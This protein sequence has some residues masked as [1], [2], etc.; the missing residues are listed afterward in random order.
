MNQTTRSSLPGRA[1]ALLSLAGLLLLPPAALPDSSEGGPPEQSG[2]G[3]M[4]LQKLL[5]DDTIAGWRQAGGDSTYDEVTIFRY[6]DGAGEVYLSFGFQ[7]LVVREFRRGAEE[8]ITA[9]VYQMGSGADAYGV[10]SR[11]RS[12]GNAGVGQ[13][14]EYRSGH[15][16]F[17]K[18]PYFITVFRSAGA[19]EAEEDVLAIGRAIADRITGE[20]PLPRIL[21]LLPDKGRVEESVRYFHTYMDL[22][23]HYF[24][25]DDNILGL[26]PE[27]E[28]AIASYSAGD[29]PPLL[30]VVRYPD[31]GRAESALRELMASFL[32]GARGPVL[33]EDGSWAAAERGG[34]HLFAL[35]D[36]PDERTAE[37]LLG[38]VIHRSEGEDR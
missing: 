1:G 34:S 35:F 30:L 14:S 3:V 11:N 21:S 8:K 17:W 29:P 12:G 32:S 26:G 18:G 13:G 6:M 31:E 5:P 4:D 25:S 36:A 10:F 16:N 28:A 33:L 2:I 37:E 38:S 22:N 9:E 7:A 23:L 20:A 19:G 27:T 24:L 15:L